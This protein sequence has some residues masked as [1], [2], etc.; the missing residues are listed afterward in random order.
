MRFLVT[1]LLLCALRLAAVGS[2]TFGN[3]GASSNHNVFVGVCAPE[4]LVQTQC[5]VG[6]EREASFRLSLA[7]AHTWA[8]EFDGQPPDNECREE[9]WND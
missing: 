9:K 6:V 2:W 7:V 5:C 4:L 3:D 1:I 8:Y